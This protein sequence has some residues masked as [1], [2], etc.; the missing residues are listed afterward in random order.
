MS[1][2]IPIDSLYLSS[3]TEKTELSNDSSS[4]VDLKLASRVRHIESVY[5]HI[6]KLICNR[7]H[8][9]PNGLPQISQSSEIAHINDIS[10]SKY[11]HSNHTIPQT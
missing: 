9:K 7:I 11:S 3:D 1:I 4:T 6:P 10:I 5:F 2:P 8:I